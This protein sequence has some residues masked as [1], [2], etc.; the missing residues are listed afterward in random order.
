MGKRIKDSL[1]AKVFLWIFGLLAVCSLL[2]YGCVMVFLPQS[3]TAAARARATD[4]L[5]SLSEELL[6]ENAEDIGTTVERFCQ[7]HRLVIEVI[8]G[9]DTQIYGTLDDQSAQWDG[10]FA[11]ATTIS[12]PDSDWTY[13]LRL[14][15]WASAEQELTS[16]FW[17][18]LP[19]ILALILFISAL[20]AFLCSRVLV[21]PI[22]EISRISRRMADLDMTW[23]CRID[24]TDEIGL[25]ADSLNTMSRKLDEALRELES[26]NAQLREDMAHIAALSEQRRDFFAAASHE[27]KTP[28]TILKGQI[29]SMI[30]GIGRYKDTRRVLP[31]TLTEVENMERLVKEILSISKIEMEGLSGRTETVSLS[32][33]LEEVAALLHPL[34]QEKGITVRKNIAPG[35]TVQGNPSL[36]EKALHNIMSNAIC[37]SPD[38]AVVTVTLHSGLLQVCNSGTAIPE[39][40]LASLFTPF[41]RVEKSRNKATGGSGLGLYLVKTILQLHKLPCQLEN[42]TDGVCFCIKLNQN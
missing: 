21:K 2:I 8:S 24:R 13:T 3:Y 35:V 33:A 9:T 38:H 39:E 32:A 19:L 30:L 26:A 25:L 27:L 16:A 7:E 37:H 40:D 22:L 15:A 36:L 5:L 28:I 17:K 6:Q 11:F 1:T 12:S 18:L 42:G 29:E 14:I 23:D 41:Y 34:A 20:G 4:E 10:S 31:E